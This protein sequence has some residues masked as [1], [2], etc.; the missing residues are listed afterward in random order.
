MAKEVEEGRVGRPKKA[1]SQGERLLKLYDMLHQGKRLRSS[2]LAELFDQSRRTMER[3]IEALNRVLEHQ[4]VRKIRPDGKA[5]H[6]LVRESRQWKV[7]SWQVLAILVGTKMTTFM[8]GLRFATEIE[9]LLDQLRYSL[10][11]G[12]RLVLDRL[13]KKLHVR[14]T[15]HKRYGARADVQAALAA[16]IDGLL[17]QQPVELT[18][19]SHRRRQSEKP[20]RELVVHPL[21]LVL[22]RGG[23]YVVVDVVDGE[24]TAPNRRI[25]LAID[26]IE[27]ARRMKEA[28]TFEYPTDY[29]PDDYFK[30]AFGIMG[31]HELHNIVLRIDETY[32]PYVMERFWHQNQEFVQQP[33]GSLIMHIELAAFD[34]I[35]DWI[36]GMGEH[37]EVLEPVELREIVKERLVRALDLYE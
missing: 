11:S 9:P 27:S 5:E 22:H 25:M 19:S 2:E 21:S 13:E 15:G 35:V 20:P 8:S 3:D 29:D 6:S 4:I 34:E 7:T 10:T 18:Y 14:R 31:G 30:G 1:Y 16:M 17:Y 23:V 26:R 12:N 28:P 36:L 33:N 37:V 32:A 24:W